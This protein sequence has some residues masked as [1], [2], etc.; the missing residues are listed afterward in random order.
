[1]TEI[2]AALVR[3]KIAVIQRDLDDLAAIEGLSLDE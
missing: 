1:M 3:R 2:D